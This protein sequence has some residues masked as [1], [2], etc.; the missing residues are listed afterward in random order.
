MD[1]QILF[2]INNFVNS[3]LTVVN[4]P[5][6]SEI[7]SF[8]KNMF[9]RKKW[10]PNYILN[11]FLYFCGKPT[12]SNLIENE[13]TILKNL[14]GS[15][16]GSISL[17]QR[18]VYFK[19]FLSTAEYDKNK[20]STNSIFLCNNANFCVEISKLG[21][22]K[23]NGDCSTEKGFI[24]CKKYTMH[25]IN[26]ILLEKFSNFECVCYEISDFYSSF[27]QAIRLDNYLIKKI[28]TEN[29]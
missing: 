11:D 24:F 27:S 26:S 12:K 21:V 15:N 22:V 18:A 16:V 14:F 10:K 4:Q 5:S 2:K 23:M 1:K 17:F 9:E 6:H 25:Q 28:D 13:L 19:I 8:K 29:F 20:I 3:S 7:E